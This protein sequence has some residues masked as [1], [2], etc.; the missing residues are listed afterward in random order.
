[1][2]ERDYR[3]VPRTLL[4]SAS[5]SDADTEEQR[6]SIKSFHS[7]ISK[8]EENRTSIMFFSSVVETME[9]AS[10]DDPVL[11]HAKSQIGICENT[12]SS[13]NEKIDELLASDVLQP[14]IQKLRER[15]VAADH[16]EFKRK[17]K[18]AYQKKL[19]EER[20]AYYEERRALL[21]QRLENERSVPS[22]DNCSAITVNDYSVNSTNSEENKSCAIEELKTRITI[23]LFIFL[24]YILFSVFGA[25]ATAPNGNRTVYITRTGECYH[26]SSCSSLRYSKFET[27]IQEAVDRGYRRCKICDPPKLI[28]EK[29]S[30]G[31]IPLFFYIFITPLLS[32][33]EW[34]VSYVPI[35]LLGVD[36][37]DVKF[38]WHYICALT[39]TF[40]VDVIWL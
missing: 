21:L 35:S 14:L 30:S 6:L 11:L 32:I 10:Q 22:E 36:P 17:Q 37:S 29:D 5:E 9:G 2:S 4:A 18:E 12:I 33:F 20:N 40:I 3:Y 13:L 19:E 23:F 15:A 25:I 24:F 27:T 34:A 26:R 7:L 16:A 31:E 28:S 8:I 1:M 39:F 38:R